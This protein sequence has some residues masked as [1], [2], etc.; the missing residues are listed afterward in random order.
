MLTCCLMSITFSARH[1]P[2]L[3]HGPSLSSDYV[4]HNAISSLTEGTVPPGLLMAVLYGKKEMW[5]WGL[6]Q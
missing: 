5:L 6:T 4:S 2:T 3:L 1:V